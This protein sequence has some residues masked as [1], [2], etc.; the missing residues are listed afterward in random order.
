MEKNLLGIYSDEIFIEQNKVIEDKIIT[1]QIVKDD[2]NIKK[3][4]L[5]DVTKFIM[6][7]FINIGITYKGS[8]LTQKKALLGSIYA[9]N[10]KWGRYPGVSNTANLTLSI[11]VY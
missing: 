7:K 8:N 11:N 1:A 3:Y 6:D 5:E 10:L 2:S 4:N 9:S